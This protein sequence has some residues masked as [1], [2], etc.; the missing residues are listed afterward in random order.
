MLAIPPPSDSV[1]KT[2][3][4]SIVNG[5]LA[6]FNPEVRSL[7][8]PVVLA[9][10]DAYNRWVGRPL[11]SW[12]GRLAQHLSKKS[13]AVQLL[14]KGGLTDKRI[15]IAMYACLL[16]AAGYLRSCCLHLQRATTPSTCVT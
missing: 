9:S 1:T 4:S 5:F 11:R 16:R 2:I 14:T 7:S 6:E 3:L 12:G 13:V 8:G 15:S 10:I